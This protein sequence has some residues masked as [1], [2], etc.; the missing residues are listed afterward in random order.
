MVNDMVIAAY[1]NNTRFA[2]PTCTCLGF[3]G[4]VLGGGLTR[5][6]GLYGAGVDQI[7][8]VNLVT[9]SG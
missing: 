4:A 7:V 1:A 8:S 3:L 2:N 5:E 6:M 9:A